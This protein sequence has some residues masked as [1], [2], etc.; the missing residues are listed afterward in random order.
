M[1]TDMALIGYDGAESLD[2]VVRSLKT[3]KTVSGVR[4]ALV[5]KDGEDLAKRPRPTPT[6]G[7][8]S[9]TPCWRA[10]ARRGPR[11]SW[12]MATRAT[13]RCWTWTARRSTCPSRASAAAPSPTAA[14]RF[15]PTSTAIL[16][17]DRGIYRPGET[18][19]LTAMVRDRL[20]KAVNDR[21]GY[22]L[23]KRPS[24]VEFKRYPSAAPTPA[25]CW[26]TSPCRAAR[27]AAAG[28]RC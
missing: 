9:P 7:C 17:A 27:R 20:A 8:A 18:V 16:Y 3:A 28:R 2:V 13:W 6:A 14:G 21:K 5:A 12:P 15:P 4:V 24:G 19:H 1:F 10:T 23:V 26:P 22:I 11:W 25:P